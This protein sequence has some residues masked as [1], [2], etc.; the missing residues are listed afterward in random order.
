MAMAGV[1]Y[2]ESYY[3]YPTSS[4][5]H[6]YHHPQPQRVSQLSTGTYYPRPRSASPVQSRSMTPTNMRPRRATTPNSYMAMTPAYEPAPPM[7][8][9]ITSSGARRNGTPFPRAN[10][11]LP[12]PESTQNIEKFEYRSRSST[13]PAPSERSSRHT[14]TRSLEEDTTVI[15]SSHLREKAST[16]LKAIS[17]RPY[18]PDS[19]KDVP[20]VSANHRFVSPKQARFYPSPSTPGSQPSLRA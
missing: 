15:S 19:V 17:S 10:R 14:H 7:P 12:A 3:S 6:G 8:Q 20:L 2:E 11:H 5:Y 4:P 18:S 13:V 16:T 9:Y 1:A